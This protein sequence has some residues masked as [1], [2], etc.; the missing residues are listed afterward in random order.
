MTHQCQGGMI[1]ELL[2]VSKDDVEFRV[3]W[4]Q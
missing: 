1:L 4:A 3:S 2:L